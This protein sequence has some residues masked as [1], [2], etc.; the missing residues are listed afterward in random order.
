MTFRETYDTL[1]AFPETSKV[2][3]C[4]G[5]R[6][7]PRRPEPRARQ[8]AA[9]TAPATV[10]THVEQ[11]QPQLDLICNGLSQRDCLGLWTGWVF[12]EGDASCWLKDETAAEAAGGPQLTS[13]ELDHAYQRPGSNP[14][15]CW[16]SR[17][18]TRLP[19][20]LIAEGADGLTGSVLDIGAN[21]GAFSARLRESCTDCQLVMFEAVPS[22]ADYCEAH[23]DVRMEVVKHGLS[24]ASGDATLWVSKDPSNRGWNTMVAGQAD[25]STMEAVSVG[26]K[27]FDEWLL[28]QPTGKFSGDSAVSLIKIDTEGAE[29]RVL[30]GMHGC[31]DPPPPPRAHNLTAFVWMSL[32]EDGFCFQSWSGWQESRRFSLRSHGEVKEAKNT[33]NGAKTSRNLNGCLPTATRGMRWRRSW[34]QQMSSS[35]RAEVRPRNAPGIELWRV[36]LMTVKMMIFSVSFDNRN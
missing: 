21:V 22:Y 4:L 2:G 5:C 1:L 15:D 20:K 34:A 30:R 13:G 27:T 26:F 9:A 17:I 25:R 3:I 12:V 24:D 28:G 16:Y 31:K 14:L 36:D 35:Y 23:A 11:S 6:G 7:G 10:S 18:V 8:R 29:W 19:A 33:P 32:R